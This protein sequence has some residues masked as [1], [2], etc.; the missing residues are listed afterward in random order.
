M[1]VEI[2][3]RSWENHLIPPVQARPLTREPSSFERVSEEAGWVDEGVMVTCDQVKELLGL[4][5]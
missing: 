4:W 3:L 5:A 2:Q 1:R